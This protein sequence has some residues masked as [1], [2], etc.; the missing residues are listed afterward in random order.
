MPRSIEPDELLRTRVERFTRMLQAV[1][2][3][4]VTALHRTRVAS[5]RLRELLPVLHLEPD[6][7]HKFNRRLRRI[8]AR[9]GTVREFDVL[10][11]LIDELKEAGRYPKPALGRVASNIGEHRQNARERLLA[12]VPIDELRRVAAK[13]NKMTRVLE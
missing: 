13:L 12:K 1:E 3:G 8:T 10:L 2:E 5:R 9:L 7:T 4:D 11:G 6:V